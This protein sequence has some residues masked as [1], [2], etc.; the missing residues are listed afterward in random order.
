MDDWA[1][2]HSEI[3][4]A[5]A[6][7]ERDIEMYNSEHNKQQLR[8]AAD[9]ARDLETNLRQISSS[10]EMLAQ[11]QEDRYESEEYKKCVRDL[12]VTDPREDKERIQETKGGL[13]R[14]SYNWIID[15]VDYKQFCEDRQ[16][17]MLWIK[18][19]PGKDKTM[20]LCGMIDELRETRDK[21]LAYFF[22][23]ATHT[24]LN[25]A[26]SIL[27]GLIYLLIVKQPTLISC[28]QPKYDVMGEQLF[29]SIN[30]WGS[31]VKILTDMLR[32]PA[33]TDA[34]LV[35]DALDE[36]LTDRPRI[37]DFITASSSDTSSSVKWIISSRNFLDIEEKLDVAERKVRLSLELNAESVS[38]AVGTYIEHKVAQLA[39]T[40]KYDP[41]TSAAVQ[42]YLTLNASGAFLWVAL[43][44][45]ELAHPNLRKWQTLDRLQSFSPGLDSLYA[46]MM[47][48]VSNSDDA[49]L[50]M[51]I[52]AIASTVYRP[53]TLD[54]LG[55]LAEPL[56]KFDR[57]YLPDIIQSCGSF[58]TLREGVVSFVHQSAKDFL[59][60]KESDHITKLEV[61]Q[62]AGL[63]RDARRFVLAN[64]V[65][66]QTAPL[67]VYA[68][69][70]VFSPEDSLVRKQFWEEEPEWM[71]TKPTMEE[72]WDACLLTLEG[73]RH[74]AT[75]AV[76]SPDGKYIAS[77]SSD[78]T[79]RIW[80]ISTGD[81]KLSFQ[82]HTGPVSSVA[83]SPDGRLIASASDDRTIKIWEV[84]IYHEKHTL[85]GHDNR[86]LSVEFSP[87]GESIISASR[88]CT[89]KIWDVTKGNEKLALQG[90][91]RDVRSA[92]F[93]KDGKQVAS[94]S[95]EKTV[96]IWDAMT[97]AQI[98]VLRG[99]E[100][101]AVGID[102]SADG[103]EIV[104][105]LH[106]GKIVIWDVQTGTHKRTLSTSDWQISSAAFSADGK[107]IVSS[108]GSGAIQVW[109][110]QTGEEKLILHAHSRLLV[111]AVF[112]SDC[113]QIVS[114][115]SDHTIKVWD[116][117][118][119]EKGF[120]E[121]WYSG[122]VRPI[123]FSPDGQRV[124]S[125]FDND[126]M[127]RTWDAATGDNK[128]G[129]KGRQGSIFSAEF[130]PDEKRIA[131]LASDAT[132]RIWDAKTGHE[133]LTLRGQHTQT[134]S[135][136][137]FSPEGKQIAS[138]LQD[139]TVKTWNAESG[140][141]KMVLACSSFPTVVSFS[142]DSKRILVC[143]FQE[144]EI[145]DAETGVRGYALEGY[146]G[147]LDLIS[148]S[149][150]C[151]RIAA[152]SKFGGP[153]IVWDV[154]PTTTTMAG[155]GSIVQILD[156]GWTVNQPAFDPVDGSRLTTNFQPLAP[157]A[158]KSPLADD[159]DDDDDGDD[160]QSVGAAAVS[161]Y[162]DR[163]S[164][165]IS[166]DNR[167]IV[168]GGK[169]LLWLPPD[170]RPR[171]SAVFGSTVA[172]STNSDRV[173]VMKFA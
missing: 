152:T 46:E 71:I 114:A 115:S 1:G 102:F 79:V 121:K 16:K 131:S 56:A 19:D 171:N 4:A 26:V 49:E 55:I 78:S 133:T 140:K 45:L 106:C 8:K 81:E 68:S 42:D 91:H 110:R 170:F 70:L 14:G 137:V 28:L 6:I 9:A 105:V 173:L 63:V 64:K 10:I 127:V 134:D 74:G 20:L 120:S 48:H 30:A 60:D 41:E 168:K 104:A 80:D 95:D 139:I 122:L 124:S 75:S 162:I 111:S 144:W 22:C 166:L 23:Q 113:K 50:F 160:N 25:N 37:L 61:R 13:F 116:I 100:D 84:L 159:D 88:D 34:V 83:F 169:I 92:V 77:A 129:L 7:V 52:L 72:R 85:R 59:L 141:E 89:V 99:R 66:I 118:T 132:V 3:E 93:S 158:A 94:A 36:C 73:P 69:A 172:I 150:D 87:I 112:S 27:R 167:W 96:I 11:Q 82:G 58:L 98:L 86:V 67:Q 161:Y 18:G 97:G 107:N 5:E 145:W 76:F 29:Q 138:K 44:C 21:K 54:E 123:M 109:D 119:A 40:K 130:S 53:V 103:N 148:W 65:S 165:G 135:L 2:Q 32:H 12:C 43:V 125:M 149:P 153:V 136:A 47:K 39:R 156:V 163:G 147:A 128:F 108:L 15:H 90:H 117:A 101:R 24:N 51:N 142:P 151:R 143:N 31:L 155:G 35:V 164:Y 154:T 38:T 146:S 62:L 33:L 157:A 17:R 126:S 57:K